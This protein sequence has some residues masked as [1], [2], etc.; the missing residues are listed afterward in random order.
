MRRSSSY[1]SSSSMVLVSLKQVRKDFD[2]GLPDERRSMV[3]K[4]FFAFES[5]LESVFNIFATF[6]N[7][8]SDDDVGDKFKVSIL[9]P[10]RVDR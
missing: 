7:S 4:S 1:E 6:P 10:F 3:L 5:F 9:P 8:S 2:F